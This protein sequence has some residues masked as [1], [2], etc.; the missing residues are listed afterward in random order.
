M[1]SFIAHPNVKLFITHG[2]LLSTLETVYHGVPILGI[3]MF[4]EQKMN[5]ANSVSLGL[6]TS[7]NFRELTEET[8]LNAI[9]EVLY[10]P[11]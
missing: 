5:V 4:A 10:N 7:L 1:L 2:G 11:K 6:G 3:P 9:N 8:F